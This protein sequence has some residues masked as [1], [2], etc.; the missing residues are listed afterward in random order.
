MPFISFSCLWLALPVLCWI[1]VARM[2]GHSCLVPDLKRSLAFHWWV[3]CYLWDSHIWPLLCRS[4]FPLHP[5]HWNNV[6]S[7]QIF[8]S[9]SIETTTW[10]LFFIFSK[11]YITLIVCIYWIILAFLEYL[12]M[13]YDLSKVLLNLVCILC[14]ETLHPHSSRIMALVFFSFSVF[15]W[16]LSQSNPGLIKWIQ[17]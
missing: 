6:E 15:I 4:T 5:G 1:N 2:D 16:F 7:C 14:S 12:I 13:V 10:F 17:K 11:W 8:F 3:W 9:T